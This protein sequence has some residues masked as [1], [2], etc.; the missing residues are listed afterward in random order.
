MARENTFNR[1]FAITPS[2]TVDIVPEPQGLYVGGAGNAVLV[3]PDGSTILYS[4]LLAGIIYPFV[5][6]VRINA[7][8]TTATLLF[9]LR[10]I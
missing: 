10:N 4:G 7:T 3:Y 9:G 6:W 8:S 5:G 2:D 1:A